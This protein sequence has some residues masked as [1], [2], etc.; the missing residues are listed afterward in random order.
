MSRKTFGTKTQN[1]DGGKT[2]SALN[3]VISYVFQNVPDTR[4]AL[5]IRQKMLEL[6]GG[7]WYKNVLRT[8]PVIPKFVE[9][10]ITQPF[11]NSGKSAMKIIQRS[12]FG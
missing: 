3:Y 4:C 10:P 5:S 11:E 12:E 1:K 7:R 6:N 2:V 8:F 9:L